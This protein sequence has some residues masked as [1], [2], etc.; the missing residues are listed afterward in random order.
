MSLQFVLGNS[1]SGKSR[2]MYE[3]IIK[4]AVQSPEKNFLVI[5]PEQFTMQTQQ[6]LVRLHPDKGL[7][8]IDV[9]SFPR[10]AHR[11]FE[12]VGADRRTVLE[13][14]GK[15]LLLRRL[16]SEKADELRI[17]KGNLKKTGYLKQIKSM[18]SELTQY[19][20]DGEKMQRLL[21]GAAKKPSLFFKLQ[22]IALLYDGFREELEGRYITAEE[23]LEALCQVARQ[24]RLLRGSVIALDSFT[25]FTPIQMKLL[26]ELLCLAEEITAAVTVDTAED[27]YRIRGE[28]ELFYLSKK[29]IRAL[30]E[31]ARECGCEIR[32]PVV[33][34]W[35]T[36]PR[37]TD[38]PELAYLEA[39]LLRGKKAALF[40][41][42]GN[43][44]MGVSLHMAANPVQEAHFAARTIC[45]LV[46]EGMRYQ[47][48]AVI[49][50]DLPS[51]GSYLPHIFQEYGIPFFLDDTREVFHDPLIE[52]IRAA[53]EMLQQNFSVTSVMRWLR[54]GLCRI[55][56]GQLDILENYLLAAGVRGASQW[57]KE[58]SRKPR[59]AAQEEAEKAEELRREIW[60]A[61]EPFTA[62]AGDAR[63]TV[64]EKTEALY[65]LI[66]HF[67][68]QKQLA[69]ME[70]TFKSAEKPELQKEYAM[71]YALVME[72]FDKLTELLGEEKLPLSEYTEVLEAGFEEARLG[73]IPPTA[74]RV[75]VGDLE[76]TRLTDIRVLFFLGLND[77][78]VPALG[79][80]SGLLSDMER[81]TL[82]D[83][84]VELAPTTRQNSYIQKFY[85]YLNLTK[86]RQRLYLSCSKA[87]ADGAP[88]R[89]SYVM[90]SVQRLFPG[91]QICDEDVYQSY[92]D[93]TAT[94]Q[95]AL[96]YFLEGLQHIREG[97]RDDAFL[98]LYNWYR[99]QDGL[100]AQAEE[101]VRA[102]FSRN[103]ER[104][105]GAVAAR[106]LYGEALAGSVSRLE[107]FAACAFAH[108]LQ[109]GLRLTEREEYEFRAA[110]MG[111]VF[112]SA[113]ELYSVKVQESGY[114][115]FTMP[116][117]E[118]QRLAEACVEEICASYGQQILQDSAR[119]RY[120]V[121]RMKR[122]MRRTVN[123][124]HE[125]IRSGNFYPVG[126]EVS[127]AQVSDLQAVN[128]ALSDKERMRLQGRI[129]RIDVCEKDDRVYVK[130]IDYKS[131]GTSFDLLAF[132]YGLQLQL[133]VYLNAAM[134]MERRIHKD[135]QVIPAGILYYHIQ[136]PLLKTDGEEEP[137]EIERD[138]LRKLR[139]DG[140][141]SDDGD[142]LE[143]L[144]KHL[145]KTS[146]VIPV[147]L[148]RDGT[149]SRF[150]HTASQE[151]F[152][153]LSAY[154]S[155]KLSELGGRIL[156]GEIEA[157]PYQRDAGGA[158][159]YCAY[160]AVCG[161]DARTFAAQARRLKE[162][163]PEEIWEK[164][165]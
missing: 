101:L 82:K 4:A 31:L 86:P 131:G 70:E 117:E 41:K 74:D 105:I 95:N 79:S 37:F 164:L 96:A 13:E 10:L 72:L 136:D 107:K 22:D 53:L 153:Q 113:V 116:K 19:D 141:V 106:Q 143:N 63:T 152:E 76:R 126:F 119:N 30:T 27:V 55:E 144:D 9:L 16:I 89:P 54:T 88:M 159:D 100:R 40:Q 139:P 128:I 58:F 114:T 92:A 80:S 81:E 148:N 102:A 110:D 57:G 78:W 158:C 33:M 112:H 50:G 75:Q 44:Q 149:P 103:T 151:Q 66:C 94:P 62:R 73:M 154:V 85:L 6:E 123:T 93:R 150:S 109:Y 127:F 146:D 29:T 8:N 64:R 83:T 135:R 71:I 61:L 137:E 17:L 1:G 121:E 99:R 12:E 39:H 24:S 122:I 18:I 77:G 7:L 118:Q 15:T 3:R 51:Y 142:I 26:R 69:A 32:P 34:E 161:M 140:L 147:S 52:F 165:T 162:Y 115:W 20:I 120:M 48:M 87:A 47:D 132:Y 111:N 163:S 36:L 125:Q 59:G 28:H 14:T 2:Y 5:V 60:E 134:E 104:G 25:G 43:G 97:Q 38:S 84:G 11:V 145:E 90:Q 160:R 129:D 130:V 91:M 108:F 56:R 133:V 46:R 68:I 124:L 138:I 23:T 67:E 21:D 156:D 157:A 45:A 35:K 98:E 49:V 42:H 155:R 65:D